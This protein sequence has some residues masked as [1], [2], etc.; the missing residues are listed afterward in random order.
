[1]MSPPRCLELLSRYRVD[2]L[3]ARRGEV[4]RPDDDPFSV[5]DLLDLPV[6]VP[7]VVRPVEPELALNR[8]DLVRFEPRHERLVV[9]TLRRVDRRLDQLPRPEGAGCLCLDEREG[10]ACCLPS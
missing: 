5:L 1:M 2:E 4:P 7:V 8:V 3:R 10:Q 6:L 9:E